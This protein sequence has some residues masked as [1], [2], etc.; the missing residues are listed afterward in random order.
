MDNEY[1]HF[2]S[3][4]KSIKKKGG[5]GFQAHKG[6]ISNMIK[7]IIAEKQR[8]TIH[9]FSNWKGFGPST[10]WMFHTT[11]GFGNSTQFA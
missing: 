8:L 5:G 1:H 11:N 10:F 6:E 7:E 3:F 4:S 9:N 2:P